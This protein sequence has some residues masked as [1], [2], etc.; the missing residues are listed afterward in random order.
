MII[1]RG[2]KTPLVRVSGTS[3]ISIKTSIYFHPMSDRQVTK[4]SDLLYFLEC[5]VLVG[6][7]TSK[8]LCVLVQ[9]T[10]EQFKNF[11]P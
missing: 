7:R 6:N 2:K 3:K 8:N 10:S 9:R 11:Y 5:P 1:F 4:Y